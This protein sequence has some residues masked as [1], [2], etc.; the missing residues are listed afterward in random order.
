MTGATVYAGSR[1]GDRTHVA[2]ITPSGKNIPLPW[3][4]EVH[5]HSPDGFEWGYGGS[6]ACQLA[7]ALCLD[8]T[9][10]DRDR[11]K[12]VYLHFKD[13]VVARLER[14]SWQLPRDEVVK[15]ITEWESL[16]G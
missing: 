5:N 10:L 16:H 2:I 9:D 15:W 6:G 12:R 8:A 7:L 11:A 3:R 1:I 4:N 13:A 14:D